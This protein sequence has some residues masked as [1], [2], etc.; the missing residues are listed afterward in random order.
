ML[1]VEA[2]S[3]VEHRAQPCGLRLAEHLLEHWHGLFHVFYAAERDSRP[4]LFYRR[5]VAA[6]GDAEF[7][8]GVAESPGGAPMLTKMKLVCES[9]T[10][11][12]IFWNSVDRVV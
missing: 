5:E 9:A 12:S 4:R 8:A 3:T 1:V 6:D 11:K 7:R 10:W 2:D